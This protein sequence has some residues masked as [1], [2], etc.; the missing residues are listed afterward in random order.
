MEIIK[1][2]TYKEYSRYRKNRGLNRKKRVEGVQ[3]TEGQ[4][5]QGVNMVQKTGSMF[6]CMFVS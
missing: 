4:G 2:D 1:G 5:K 6:V 3:T